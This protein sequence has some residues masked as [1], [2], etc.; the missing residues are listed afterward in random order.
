MK[1]GDGYAPIGSIKREISAAVDGWMRSPGHR[2][3]VLDPKY[4]KVN[5][6]IAWE[7][8]NE[9]MFAHFEGDY[10][11]YDVVPT[12]GNG[13]LMLSGKVRNGMRFTGAR[14]LSVQV[15]YDRPPH[16]LTAG[17]LSRTYC[18]DN[19]RLLASLREPLSG[20]MYWPTDSYTTR[21]PVCPSPYNVPA[22]APVARSPGDAHRLWQ[23]AY[24]ASKASGDTKSVT[25]EWVTANRWTA[26][27]SQFAVEADIS[28]LL[29]RHGKGVYTV[30]VW[31]M[32]QS[33]G[34]VVIADH[35]I[36]YRATP[37]STYGPSQWNQIEKQGR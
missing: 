5:I 20:G 1:P 12:I 36:F 34:D 8:Y 17:Q 4:K 31:A 27:G 24:S 25:V 35:S 6:G 28:H 11:E 37:P 33:S 23:E 29:K 3:S 22:D 7:R 15:W 13:I 30:V 14:D 19:G 2:K 32:D 10:V 26:R 18:Y 16:R 21:I 9:V